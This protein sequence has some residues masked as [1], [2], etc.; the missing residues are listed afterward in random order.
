MTG[1]WVAQ[2]EVVIVVLL[3][4]CADLQAWLS[5]PAMLHVIAFRDNGYQY[6]QARE[7]Q[8]KHVLETTVDTASVR[9]M[10]ARVDMHF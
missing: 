4:D 9:L 8:I 3:A 2:E 10:L 5:H 1:A 7:A 6:L